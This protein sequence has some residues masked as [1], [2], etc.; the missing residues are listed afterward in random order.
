M[1]LQAATSQHPD[2][3]YSSRS[4]AGRVLGVRQDEVAGWED[5]EPDEVVVDSGMT[6]ERAAAESAKLEGWPGAG[7]RAA[8]GRGAAGGYAAPATACSRRSGSW[9]RRPTSR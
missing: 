8:R 1:V 7:L 2:L 9:P 4:R 5:L 3:R 6:P